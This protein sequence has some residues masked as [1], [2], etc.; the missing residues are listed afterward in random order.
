VW[1]AALA[2]AIFALL[3]VTTEGGAFYHIITANV[4]PLDG[5]ILQFYTDEVRRALPVLLALGGT[6][7][8][9]GVI[10]AALRRTRTAAKGWFMAAPY[11]AGALAAALTIAK[12]G[13]DVNYLY[14]L[15]AGLCLAAGVW[16]GWL[17]RVPALRAALLVALAWQVT[18]MLTLSEGKYIPIQN[19]KINQWAQNEALA[20]L[21]ATTDAPII[22][23]EHMGLLALNHRPILIQ[24]FE[25]T[26]LAR[27]GLWDQ[28]PF[29]WAL[30]QGDYPI[31][32]MYQPYRNPSLRFERWTPEMLR[33][34]NTFYRVDRQAGETMVYRHVSQNP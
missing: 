25:M 13:S 30:A 27:D 19:E 26:Q 16:A 7:L 4:N 11:L 6:L 34:I 20:T 23:D 18:T 5:A 28:T 14:E 8:V 12:V 33:V 10:G 21:V 32:L 3:V 1:L 29:L 15:A 17:R 2:L 31:L 22:A 9:V 24:P